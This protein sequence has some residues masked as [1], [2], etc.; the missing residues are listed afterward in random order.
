MQAEAASAYGM[1]ALED[2]YGPAN[3]AQAG[4]CFLLVAALSDACDTSSRRTQP[5]DKGSRPPAT[6]GHQPADTATAPRP[7]TM[8]LWPLASGGAMADRPDRKYTCCS[9]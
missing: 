1:A 2:F 5:A 3:D 9:R 4:E 7:R 6:D 8:L